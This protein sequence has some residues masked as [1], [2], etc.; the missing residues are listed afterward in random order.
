MGRLEKSVHNVIQK[1]RK[2][3]ANFGTYV[4]MGKQAAIKIDL[5]K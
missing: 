5:R 3:G 2:I 4:L 1:I